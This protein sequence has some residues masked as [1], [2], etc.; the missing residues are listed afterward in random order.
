MPRKRLLLTFSFGRSSGAMC[1]LILQDPKY[2]DYEILIGL[3]NTGWEHP[4]SLR[5]GKALTERWA[6]WGHKVTWLEAVVHPGRVACSH[7]EVNFF[8]AS[9]KGEPFIDVIRKYGIPNKGYP[10]CTRELKENVIK[11][12]A[13]SMG[14]A[15]RTYVT[16]IGIR[17]DEPK[18]L[19][20][21]LSS[22]GQIKIYPLADWYPKTKQEI[23]DY[24]SGWKHDLRI[25][26][27]QGNCVGCYRKSDKKLRQAYAADPSDFDFA[28]AMETAFGHVG[29]NKLRGK[30]VDTPRM[31]YRG[32]K[33]AYEIIQT[34][35]VG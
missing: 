9:R 6:A 1:D 13:R 20:R 16:A 24:W 27:Y 30:H 29:S 25:P 5:F 33:S 22:N 34:F 26:E 17:G 11:S 18:R 12:W 28:I 8:S 19:K 7:R 14:W 31:F 32:E 15:D 4:D 23:L 3:A 35:K 10:H 2:K 21:G